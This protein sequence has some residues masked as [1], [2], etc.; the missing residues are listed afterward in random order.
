M[1]QNIIKNMREQKQSWPFNEPVNRDDVADYYDVIQNP[2][3]LKTIEK[4]LQANVYLD[5]ETF[6]DDVK[7]MFDNCRQYNQ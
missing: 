2:I 1:C 7:R 6:I 5:K 3:D 4:K